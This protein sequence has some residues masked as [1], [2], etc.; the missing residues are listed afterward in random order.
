MSL[1][2]LRVPDSSCR[3]AEDSAF[4]GDSVWIVNP[5][6]PLQRLSARPRRGSASSLLVQQSQAHHGQIECNVI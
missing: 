6:S 1:V 4:C 3:F 2:C 5:L